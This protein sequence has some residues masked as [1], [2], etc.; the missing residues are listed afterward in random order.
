MKIIGQPESYSDMLE[1]I[2]VFTLGTS[3]LCVFWLSA[4]SKTIK[5]ILDSISMEAE[6]GF[7]KSVKALYVLIPLVVAILSRIIKLH[8]KISDFFLIRQTFDT[9]HILIPMAQKVGS[10]IQPNV[11][12]KNRVDI[13]YKL[14]YPYAG[15]KDP[16]IDAQL[17]RT[18]LDNWGWYWVILESD[19]VLFL[20]ML[21]FFIIGNIKSALVSLIIALVLI[22]LSFF[23]YR[24]CIKSANAELNA[25]IDDDK[26]KMEILD[27]FSTL[28]NSSRSN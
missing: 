8:D 6:I 27:F 2:F 1:R 22:F 24:V 26:R 18:A 19:F 11:I 20:N 13:M 3:I 5:D 14:F 9:K 7:I 10:S 25:I 28:Y 12:K 23:Q 21:I 4:T 17:V 16:Q 15:F